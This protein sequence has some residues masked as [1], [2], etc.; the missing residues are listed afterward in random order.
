MRIGIPAA[1]VAAA[2][3]A[4]PAA[5]QAELVREFTITAKPAKASTAKKKYSITL[6]A[7][8][9]QRD[10]TG[11]L[12]PTLTRATLFLPPGSTWNGDLFPKCASST[13]DAAK[14]TEDCPP[15]SIVGSGKVA[16]GAPGG[17]VQD[18]VTITAA[19]GGKNTLNLFVEGTSPLR[20]QSNIAVKL[21]K[22]SGK[23]GMRADIPVPEPLQEPAPGVPVSI[24][25]L[26]LS[27]GKSAKIKG[28]KR[29]I[30]EVTKCTGGKW[31]G[32]GTL[33]FRNAESFSA[34]QTIPCKKG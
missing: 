31:F 19:N 15:E 7:D 10:T 32:Q 34:D 21:V 4:V 2:A 6:K 22:L 30:I 9:S 11:A 17:I 5:A 23:F 12:P 13:I 14:S 16:G 33:D 18:D 8:V 24:T 27:I 20:L 25:S 29:G 3:L 28:V 26:S 1:I